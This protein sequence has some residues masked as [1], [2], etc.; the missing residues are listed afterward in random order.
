VKIF[1]DT[2]VLIPSFYGD[3]PQHDACVAILDRLGTDSVFCS[4]H[5]LVET[6][7]ALT[8]MPGKYRVSADKARL[9]IAG[10][11]GRLQAVA[12]TEAE[13]FDLINAY[14]ATGIVGGGIYDAVHARCAVKAGVEVLLTWN[15]RDFMRFEEAVTRLVK[16]PLD[17]QSTA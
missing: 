1:L 13:Y 14:G 5:S 11:C 4:S 2:S 8:R 16:T 10:L 12:L 6:Y 7:S 9:F 15:L 3:H 17:F